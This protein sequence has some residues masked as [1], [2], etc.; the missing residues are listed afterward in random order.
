[1]KQDEK[2]FLEMSIDYFLVLIKTKFVVYYQHNSQ[3]GKPNYFQ[4]SKSLYHNCLLHIEGQLHNH[5]R[6]HNHLR[7]H[8][9]DLNLNS[10][11]NQLMEYHH[12]DQEPQLQND[13]V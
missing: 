9:I 7:Q 13:L 12:R 4:L 10:M 2:A 11:T 5:Y 6:Y 3:L 1:M 8:H